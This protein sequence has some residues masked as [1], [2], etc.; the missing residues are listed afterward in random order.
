MEP[1][2]MHQLDKSFH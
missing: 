1:G 2:L